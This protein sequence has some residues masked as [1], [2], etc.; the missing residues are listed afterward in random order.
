MKRDKRITFYVD[1][2]LFDLIDRFAQTVGASRSELL[3]LFFDSARPKFRAVHQVVSEVFR[4]VESGEAEEKDLS[5]EELNQMIEN[6]VMEVV[7]GE[8]IPPY[9]NTGVRE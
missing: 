1:S 6:A 3:Y 2:E 5:V 9:S 8:A 4:M 7:R